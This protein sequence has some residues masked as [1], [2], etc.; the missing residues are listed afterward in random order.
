M[1]RKALWFLVPVALGA[2]IW[3][4]R[5]DITR[6][7]KIKQMSY[8]SGHPENV[9]ASGR[10]SYPTQRA[11]DVGQ[12]ES[13]RPVGGSAARDRTAVDPQDPVDTSSPNF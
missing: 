13:G 1:V 3:T 4:Q 7:V 2:M 11:D 12:Y 9:P 6:Y 10:I 5:S 8:G